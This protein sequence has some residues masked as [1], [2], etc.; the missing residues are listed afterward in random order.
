MNEKEIMRK[1]V[2]TW[3]SNVIT[4]GTIF[5]EKIGLVVELYIKVKLN[6]NP[7]FKNIK[8]IFSNSSWPGEGEHKI[9][10]FI[11]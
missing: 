8:C 5:M 3:D 11:R 9:L 2:E 1:Y 10:E 7:K 6:V 4:P